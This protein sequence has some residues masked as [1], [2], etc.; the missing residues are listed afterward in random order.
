MKGIKNFIKNLGRNYYLDFIVDPYSESI[1]FDKEFVKVTYQNK[2]YYE[3][4]LETIRLRQEEII[5]ELK[6]LYEDALSQIY[7]KLATTSSETLDNFIT[8]NIEA[9][10]ICLKKIKSD[11]YINDKK[12]RYYS[13]VDDFDIR[14]TESLNKNEFKK[15][16]YSNENPMENLF[17]RL[18]DN[19]ITGG[20]DFWSD[21]FLEFHYERIKTLSWLPFAIFQIGNKF[22]IDLIRIQENLNEIRKSNQISLKIK[23]LGKKTH[24]GFIFSML[25]QEGYIDTP[26]LKNGEINYTA[27]SRIIKELFEVDV[28]EGTLRKYLNPLDDKFEENQNTF[29]K[30]KF[31]LPNVKLVN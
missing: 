8:F 19:N 23:W 30:E 31:H 10:K 2:F 5:V 26:K 1:D 6:K 14:E 18:S 22:I 28:T 27:F 13:L 7:L 20:N 12:S 24:I 25:S 16:D 3:N 4:N 29:E 21:Y 17:K 15:S 9:I 11:F